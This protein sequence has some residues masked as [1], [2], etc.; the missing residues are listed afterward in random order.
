[1]KFACT[2]VA[3]SIGCFAAVVLLERAP[4]KSEPP[5]GLVSNKPADLSENFAGLPLRGPLVQER[6]AGLGDSATFRSKLSLVFAHGQ[7]DRVW[8]AGHNST[9]SV[10]ATAS[11]QTL[12]SNRIRLQI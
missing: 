10:P 2:L 11:H 12:Q 6:R 8:R 4:A 5:V 9:G 3:C 7:C 1:M